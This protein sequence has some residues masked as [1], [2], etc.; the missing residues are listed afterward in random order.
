MVDSGWGPL[1]PRR[2]EGIVAHTRTR[3][4]RWEDRYRK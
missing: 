2:D 4:R 3:I 1:I